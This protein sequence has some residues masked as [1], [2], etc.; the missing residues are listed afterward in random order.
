[1]RSW[2]HSNDAF[3]GN[4]DI[5]NQLL[6]GVDSVSQRGARLK[7]DPFGRRVQKEI[8]TNGGAS[9]LVDVKYYY[10]GNRVIEERA[11]D[12]SIKATYLYGSESVDDVLATMRNGA[13]YFY[14]KN[15]VGS[16]V[17]IADS[18]GTVIERYLYSAFGTPTILETSP[19]WCPGTIVLNGSFADSA[20]AGAMP[21]VGRTDRWTR[22]YLSPDV[23]IPGGFDDS[24]YIGMY[25]NQATGEAIQQVMTSP[26]V[27]G[28]TYAI[29]CAARWIREPNRPFAPQYAFRAS[30]VS[31]TSPSDPN[32][33]LIG[34]SA[35]IDTG[36]WVN[37]AIPDWVAPGNYN[38]LT[39]SITN[40]SN[41]PNGDSVTYAHVDNICIRDLSAPKTRNSSIIGNRIMFTGREYDP[42]IRMYNYRARNYVPKFG[43]FAQPDPL[44]PWGDPPHRG[45]RYTY[46]VNSPTVFLD[47]LGK[48]TG[49]PVP[50]AEIFVEQEPNDE[51]I[52]A[53]P[54][55]GSDNGISTKPPWDFVIRTKIIT[56][57]P[58]PEPEPAP[59]APGNC[60]PYSQSLSNLEDNGIIA[61]DNNGPGGDGRP[62][63]P[64][65]MP[66]VPG[67]QAAS[68]SYP[69]D[70]VGAS[71]G[72]PSVI[73]PS[74]RGSPVQFAS[75][76]YPVDFVGASVGDPSVIA[77]G[78]GN[79]GPGGGIKIKEGRI[80]KLILPK[81]LGIRRVTRPFR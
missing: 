61:S 43:R 73:R 22:A 67:T 78:S 68:G 59:I 52:A 3:L 20:R 31:L 7:H 71:V 2:G 28:H 64:P 12:N 57:K 63:G 13:D 11:S 74:G 60:G 51:P 46:A 70:F 8:T 41:V 75:G 4:Y 16:I 21:S 27:S 19:S 48:M 50:G 76:S 15:A 42:E 18:A 17:A 39:V 58:D 23:K 25:G 5:R 77:A 24:V 53:D 72:D 56:D 65:G 14:L 36:G 79:R 34:V 49:E 9:W 66:P 69:V 32:G 35:A 29:S 26:F 62:S 40:G 33:V 47:P 44:G 37:I 54:T 80:K 55:G 1:M 38:I 30:N 81:V 10:S 6:Q 45:N